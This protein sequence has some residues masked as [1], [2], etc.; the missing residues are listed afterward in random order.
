MSQAEF[1]ALVSEAKA[2]AQALAISLRASG[3]APL[4]A[5]ADVANCG[6]R[7]VANCGVAT[8]ANCGVAEVANCS[9]SAH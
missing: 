2:A 1:E 9:V 5:A 4:G 3:A 6:T 7:D 8:V